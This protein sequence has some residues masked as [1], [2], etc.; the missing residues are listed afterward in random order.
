MSS[1]LLFDRELKGLRWRG[2]LPSRRRRRSG[3]CM[4]NPTRQLH[5]Q[6]AA[7]CFRSCHVGVHPIDLRGPI[8]ALGQVQRRRR[9]LLPGGCTVDCRER[10]ARVQRRTDSLPSAR[11]P[12]LS[13][14]FASGPSMGRLD[15][16]IAGYPG[17]VVI[18][19]QSVT[20]AIGARH[21]AIGRGV[22]LL[23]CV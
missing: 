18:F 14:G 5:G 12:N 13:R 22:T 16:T 17:S 6:Q 11:L 20:W 8:R 15:A 21:C 7:R 2:T 23:G 1:S 10:F 9:S 4:L 19:A 3:L